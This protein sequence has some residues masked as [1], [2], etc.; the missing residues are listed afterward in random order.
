MVYDEEDGVT[1][2]MSALVANSRALSRRSPSP[3]L[4]ALPEPSAQQPAQATV[5]GQPFNS[6]SITLR[7]IFVILD[8]SL[9]HNGL[10][11]VLH[12]GLRILITVDFK[13]NCRSFQY[14]SS[15]IVSSE[16]DW[17]HLCMV[18]GHRYDFQRSAGADRL[19]GS[20][21]RESIREQFYSALE[22]DEHLEPVAPQAC[23]VS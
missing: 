3:S 15:E 20:A 9:L 7:C 13:S 2:E 22:G 21:N 18:K 5:P 11:T 16:Q 4:L 10:F 19:Y 23:A 8:Q 6:C 17:Q 1:I 12:E 14:C